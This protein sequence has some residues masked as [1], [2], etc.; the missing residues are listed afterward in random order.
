M[1]LRVLFAGQKM[2]KEI[3]PMARTPTNE[4]AAIILFTMRLPS[5]HSQLRSINR[6]QIQVAQSISLSQERPASMKRH[7][8]CH[9][10]DQSAPPLAMPLPRQGLQ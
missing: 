9:G 2:A 1:L 3:T 7:F 10:M 4:T 8:H 5:G 6:E